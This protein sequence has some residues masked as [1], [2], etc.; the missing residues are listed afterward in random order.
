MQMLSL[1]NCRKKNNMVTYPKSKCPITI[2]FIQDHK[3]ESFIFQAAN[4][5]IE[6]GFDQ[7]TILL[8]VIIYLKNLVETK[9]KILKAAKV[10]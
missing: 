4:R 6:E 10:A 8:N 3:D 9:D 7:D 2:N 1:L 5:M